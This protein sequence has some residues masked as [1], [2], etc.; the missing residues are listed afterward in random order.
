MMLHTEASFACHLPSV[1][2]ARLRQGRPAPFVKRFPLVFLR[3][4][5]VDG[6]HKRPVS[7]RLRP[8]RGHRS[9]HRP[10]RLYGAA[11]ALPPCEVPSC[12][13]TR[14]VSRRVQCV[15]GS[16]AGDGRRRRKVGVG[17]QGHQQTIWLLREE[18][19]RYLPDEGQDSDY[20]FQE[21]SSSLL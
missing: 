6:S 11:G 19:L 14:I 18:M 4:V 9:N 2:S 13:E 5:P 7:R 17:E 1:N 20:R 10:V 15:H 21:D 8:A 3:A 16:G 12:P